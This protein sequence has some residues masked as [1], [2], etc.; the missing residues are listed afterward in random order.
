MYMLLSDN[1]SYS[2]NM[3]Q[4][5]QCQR[6]KNEGLHMSKYLYYSR[7]LHCSYGRYVCCRVAMGLNVGSTPL[8]QAGVAVI[9]LFNVRTTHLLQ[10]VL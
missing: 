3:H 10:P 4:L 5:N 8:F 9:L 2:C 1:K 6:K 7:L